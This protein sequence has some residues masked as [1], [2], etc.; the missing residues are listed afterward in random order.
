MFLDTM[1]AAAC[2]PL[3]EPEMQR[4]N[5]IAGRGGEQEH[6]E[7][8]EGNATTNMKKASGLKTGCLL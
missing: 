2:L 1:P 3:N 6:N 8:S 4:C 5:D 7:K